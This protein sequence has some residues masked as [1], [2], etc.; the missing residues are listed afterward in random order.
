MRLLQLTQLE[1]AF[2]VA[3][4][5]SG[6]PLGVSLCV[7]LLS[8][9]F[10]AVTQIQEQ[11]L[12]F[13]PKLFAVSVVLYA[14]SGWWCGLVKQQCDQALGSIVLVGNRSHSR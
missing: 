10:Q 3:L 14:M 5:V 6:I 8:A 9:V 2:W 13:V 7:G 12:S 11:A 4:L 1:Q